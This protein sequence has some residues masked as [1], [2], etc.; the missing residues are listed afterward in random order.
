MNL[1]QN[2]QERYEKFFV[3]FRISTVIGI[4]FSKS[5]TLKDKDVKGNQDWMTR[6]VSMRINNE[7][8]YP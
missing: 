8:G 6:Y 3:M 5:K 7:T 1:S 4:C 2:E